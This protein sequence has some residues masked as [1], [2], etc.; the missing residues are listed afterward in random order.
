MVAAIGRRRRPPVPSLRCSGSRAAFWPAV[1][2]L[3]FG[4]ALP[5]AG[6][7]QPFSS[8]A[9]DI[10]HLTPVNRQLDYIN[11][12]QSLGK[13]KP[14]PGPSEIFFFDPVLLPVTT[15]LDDDPDGGV[16]RHLATASE[17]QR[18]VIP[19]TNQRGTLSLLL[20]GNGETPLDSEEGQSAFRSNGPALRDVANPDSGIPM[21]ESWT[22]LIAGA[23]TGM[24]ALRRNR[25]KKR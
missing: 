1:G 10:L 17:I 19:Q 23:S 13:L 4:A 5:A 2:L 14:A 20:T 12:Q 9:D 16:K 11:F 15:W 24:M 22:L 8:G 7:E 25:N 3:L 18:S 6:Q 21:T